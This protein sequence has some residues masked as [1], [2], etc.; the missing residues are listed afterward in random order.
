MYPEIG[1]NPHAFCF[2]HP[3]YYA[4]QLETQE[5]VTHVH[6]A[7]R[8]YCGFV[9]GWKYP[10]VE[11]SEEYIGALGFGVPRFVEVA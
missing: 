11:K 4:R 1:C 5:G 9:A 6:V 3:S 8:M 2:E 7:F 10:P